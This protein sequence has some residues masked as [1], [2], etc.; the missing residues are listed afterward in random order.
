MIFRH[1]AV[2]G[3][4]A[5]AKRLRHLARQRGLVFLVAGDPRL[6]ARVKADGFHAPE[7]LI[8]RTIF[9]RGLLPGGLLTVAAH[10][11][12]GLVSAARAKA[13]LV[14]LS[15]VFPTQSHARAK[16]LGVLRFTALATSSAVP[17]IAL[18]GINAVTAQRLSA[19]PIAGIAAIGALMG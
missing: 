9:A 6:A 12:R 3:R 14:L 8:S 16:P 17:V 7:A 10:G 2:P 15:P 5:E 1:Y 19:A 11:A 18:G 4:E 13:D